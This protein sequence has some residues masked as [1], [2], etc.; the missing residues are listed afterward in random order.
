MTRPARIALV[1]ALAG[2]G[3]RVQP[4]QTDKGADD[5]GVGPVVQ[6]AVDLGVVPLS[7]TARARIPLEDLQGTIGALEVE[8][9]IVA[10]ADDTHGAVLLSWTPSAEGSLSATVH[11]GGSHL[12]QVQ[13]SAVAA[14]ALL[15]SPIATSIGYEALDSLPDALGSADLSGSGPLPF[16]A[17]PVTGNAWFGDPD[18]GRA[19]RLDVFYNHPTWGIWVPLDKDEH[20][21]WNV[22]PACFEEPSGLTQNGSCTGAETDGTG[23][24]PKGW[25]FFHGGFAGD[26]ELSG[27]SALAPDEA[28]GR[29][30]ALGPGWLRAI[31]VDLNTTA[32]EGADP[33]TYTQV[34]PGS[35]NL[36]GDWATPWGQVYD[37]RLWLVDL[38][39]GRIGSWTEGEAGPTTLVETGES[40]VAAGIDEAG[41]LLVARADGIAAIDLAS[42][43]TTWTIPLNPG[44]LEGA[45]GAV[46]ADGGR[47]YAAWGD[48]LLIAGEDGARLLLPPT[49]GTLT[50]LA[51]DRVSGG[52]ATP[53]EILYVAGETNGQGWLRAATVEGA[54]VGEPYDLAAP[55]RAMGYAAAAHDLY[56]LY[57]AGSEGCEGAL[58]DLCE[59]GTHPAVVEPM[60]DPYGLVP[61]TSEGH[62]LNLFLY[63]I[64]ETPKDSDIDSDFTQGLGKCPNTDDLEA[65]CCA[66]AWAL[67]NRLAPNLAYLEGTLLEVG[68][69]TAS[70]DDDPALA[71]GINP[72]FLRQA[73]MCLDSEEPDWQATGKA[74]FIAIAGLS[75]PRADLTA[76]TH[77]A[78]ATDREEN[79]N[80]VWFL[81]LLYEEGVDYE[82]P[83]DT[84]EEYDMLHH[85][86]AAI[87]DT[88]DDPDPELAALDLDTPICSG[89]G[90]DSEDVLANIGPAGSWV[91]AV[92]DGP[93]ALGLPARRAF[94][95]LSSGVD[96]T[97]DSR[98]YRRKDLWPLDVR[99]RAALRWLNEDVNIPEIPDPASGLVNLPGISYELGTLVNL[100][101]AGALRESLKY[102]QTVTA[103][104]WELISRYLRRILA[105]SQPEAVKCW[106]QHVFDVVHAEGLLTEN[107]GVTGALDINV[108]GI[109]RINRELVEPGYARWA[110]P[111]AVLSEWEA[112][113]N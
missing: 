106:Y 42:G 43:Q 101:D 96:P 74:A 113:G 52:T 66:L 73:R 64:I 109:D 72:S 102:G 61:P 6:L 59:A 85:G 86:L 69:E 23:A 54:W 26:G 31:D 76:W 87:Y 94:T 7:G 27:L 70:T 68:G 65:G 78:L 91:E 93:T 56:L 97:I 13:G 44:S 3:F 33:Y 75:G 50:G 24:P 55:P 19:W 92:R 100:S 99:E 15:P 110:P 8:G 67:E 29:I 39:S 79:Q 48:A 28:A 16:A 60:Y 82:L 1:L 58:A 98:T 105:S 84:Q 21:A 81:D 4:G 22:A 88:R 18:Q 2:C 25:R 9:D 104:H 47:L 112:S 103:G 53:L 10:E 80:H 111:T 45:P 41:H 77:T 20:A 17:D 62:P 89:N 63:P 5:T 57:A 14:V 11:V 35:T 34:V 30:W 108:D 49:G 37:S 95:F 71:W 38:D 32:D 90:L 40:V 46:L 51:I 12:I 36:G 83:V 107:S